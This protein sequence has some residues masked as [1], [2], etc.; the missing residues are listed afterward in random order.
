QE[1]IDL[2]PYTGHV[3]FLVWYYQLL[4]VDAVATPAWMIDDVSVTLSRAS[5]IQ[6]SNNLSQAQFTLSGPAGT[7]TGQGILTS[8]TNFTG[9]QYTVTFGAV[10]YYQTP[11]SQTQ[12]LADG[13]FLSFIGN[14]TFTDSN[15]NGMS[16][17]W[18]QQVFGTVSPT[19]T[20]STDTDRDGA[21]D[22]A[23]FVAGTNPNDPASHLKLLTPALV[24]N[25]SVRLTWPSSLG[26]SYRI[27][28]SANAVSWHPLTDWVRASATSTTVTLPR[29]PAFLF[30]LEVRP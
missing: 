22:Y 10:P 24:G 16:D 15:N 29:G 13:A 4:S 11:A 20:A 27:Q 8:Y 28:G 14:Y 19:R 25:N 23:E 21:T 9:G 26:R 18:E 1:E 30:K 2:S 17:A 6:I 5:V 12:T 7:R 3:V